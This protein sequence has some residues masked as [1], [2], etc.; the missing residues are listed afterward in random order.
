MEDHKEGKAKRK[1]PDGDKGEQERY[2][3]AGEEKA[4]NDDTGQQ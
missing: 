1:R 3:E 2:E 4:Q